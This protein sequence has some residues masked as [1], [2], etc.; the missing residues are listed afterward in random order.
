MIVFLLIELKKWDGKEFLNMIIFLFL[1][2][3]CTKISIW[4]GV[5]HKIWCIPAQDDA[6][7]VLQQ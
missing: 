3:N 6:N 7:E 1:R 5:E 2:G 4:T